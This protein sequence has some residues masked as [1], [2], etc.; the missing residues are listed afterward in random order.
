MHLVLSKPMPHAP[1]SLSSDELVG[2]LYYFNYPGSTGL[3]AGSVFGRIAGRYDLLNHLLSFNLDKRNHPIA[4][5]TIN[6]R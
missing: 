4:L 6:E 3:M 2:G 5:K 1:S